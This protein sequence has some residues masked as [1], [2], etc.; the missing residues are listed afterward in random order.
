MEALLK[1][2]AAPLMIPMELRGQEFRLRASGGF[3]GDLEWTS[4]AVGNIIKNCFGEII[5]VKESFE[6]KNA[7]V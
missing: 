1:Q 5:C 7:R 4:E 6:S 3:Y 2:S